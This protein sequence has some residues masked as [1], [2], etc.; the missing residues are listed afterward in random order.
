M[1]RS[2]YDCTNY[3]FEIEEKT[4][5]RKYGKSKEHRPNPISTNGMFMDGDGIPLAFLYFQYALSNIY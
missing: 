4:E 5:L 2:F 3:Y 1:I